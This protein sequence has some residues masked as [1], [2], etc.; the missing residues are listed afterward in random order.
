MWSSDWFVYNTWLL[1]DHSFIVRCPWTLLWWWWQ[2]QSSSYGDDSFNSNSV[3][4]LLLM[5]AQ[6]SVRLIAIFSVFIF[7]STHFRNCGIQLFWY[8]H[9][10]QFNC[11]QVNS[12]TSCGA[13][14]LQFLCMPQDFF[15]AIASWQHSVEKLARD[16]STNRVC[17]RKKFQFL[18]ANSRL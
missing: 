11:G 18:G 9:S 1:G 14:I 8:H 7:S 16:A 5:Y 12:G 13:Q 17:L 4:K 10:I 6:L 15:M 2:L 3:I